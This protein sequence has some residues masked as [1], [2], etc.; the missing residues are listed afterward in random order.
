MKKIDDKFLNKLDEMEI[1]MP[2][3]SE[4]KLNR[5]YKLEMEKVGLKK[6]QKKKFNWKVRKGLV[7]ACF[8]VAFGAAIPS[9]F[10]QINNIKENPIA[11]VPNDS[12]KEKIKIITSLKDGEHSSVVELSKGI[13]N[14]GEATPPMDSIMYFDPKTTTERSL[15]QKEYIEYLGVDPRPSYMIAG[16]IEQP[17]DNLMIIKNKNGTM[18]YD[19][20]YFNYFSEDNNKVLTISTSKGGYPK[21]CALIA[22]ESESKSNINGIEVNV[23][24]SLDSMYVATFMYKGIGYEI[25]SYNI[26]QKEFINVLVSI[27]Q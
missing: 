1:D 27:L 4:E 24:H 12:V 2:K 17:V 3:L 7:A 19:N 9:I 10:N 18:A 11:S 14:F 16:L 8:V 15:T 13:L 5:I 26:S 20:G 25:E 21:N 22:T 6:P 23:G